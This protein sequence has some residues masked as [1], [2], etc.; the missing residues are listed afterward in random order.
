MRPIDQSGMT[1]E[2]EMVTRNTRC[3]D[4]DGFEGCVGEPQDAEDAKQKPNAV[5]W[6]SAFSRRRSRLNPRNVSRTQAM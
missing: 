6:H 2:P 5:G 4:D 1:D 3:V